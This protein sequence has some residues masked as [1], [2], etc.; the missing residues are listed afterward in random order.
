MG[1][2]VIATGCTTSHVAHQHPRT[3]AE[4]TALTPALALEEL[5]N[6][7]A[8]FATGRLLSRDLQA[9][10]TVTAKGQYPSAFILSCIDSRVGSEII[11]DQGLGDV[12]NARLAGNVLDET[13][14]GSMEFACKVAGAK[15]VVV[16]GH[17]AC[18]AIQGACA[19]VQMGNLTTLLDRIK[20]AVTQARLQM[21]RAANSDPRFVDEVA[22]LNVRHVMEQ[23]PSESDVMRDLLANGQVQLVGGVYDLGSG[24][25]KWLAPK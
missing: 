14:L 6:G 16:L 9:E 11:F 15:L 13:V 3:K 22:E 21:P 4:Q 23:I 5:K 25:I 2:L 12:F 17:S 7:N 19:D 24:R 1:L 10:R 8:R 20:P 18:G